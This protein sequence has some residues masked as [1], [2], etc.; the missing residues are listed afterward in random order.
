MLEKLFI[1]S[2]PINQAKLYKW[3]LN[4]TKYFKKY[5]NKLHAGPNT[6]KLTTNRK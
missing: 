3:D 4:S 6:N 2:R 1:K 5:L